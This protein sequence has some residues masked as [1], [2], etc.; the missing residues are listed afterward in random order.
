[1]VTFSLDVINVGFYLLI[2]LIGV[3]FG[4]KYIQIC[5]D[6]SDKYLATK[7]RIVRKL[8]ALLSIACIYLLFYQPFK[9][10]LV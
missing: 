5:L 4:F 3:S 1:M 7:Y 9:L 6:E 8:Y 2:F 10:V